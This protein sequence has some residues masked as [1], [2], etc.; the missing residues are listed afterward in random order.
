MLSQKCH[1]LQPTASHC[2]PRLGECTSVTRSMNKAAS[3]VSLAALNVCFVAS[4][5]ASASQ[6]ALPCSCSWSSY[7]A[8]LHTRRPL[9]LPFTGQQLAAG[10]ATQCLGHGT[11]ADPG[12]IH[13]CNQ[14]GQR[15]G[16]DGTW[17]GLFGCHTFVTAAPVSGKHLTQRGA[18]H[19]LAPARIGSVTSSSLCLTWRCLHHRNIVH[20]I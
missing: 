15:T 13:C 1:R 11:A 7:L 16:T 4:T 12:V 14:Q 18:C 3:W 17:N 8:N 20:D 9:A 5:L 6:K 2:K 10:A 19:P